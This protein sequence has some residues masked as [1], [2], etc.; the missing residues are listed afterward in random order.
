MRRDALPDADPALADR[1]ERAASADAV[2]TARIATYEHERVTIDTDAPGRRLFVL[3]DT[4]FPGW[5]A[6]VDG[7]PT[8][9]LRANVAFRAVPLSPGRH[10]VVFEYAP[11]SF[12]IGASD[13]RRGAAA[14]S[15][16]GTAL[17]ERR[18]RAVPA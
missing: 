8:P 15:R 3:S 9:I 5:R 13:R 14:R 2:G 6:T 18:R 10:R 7:T 11:A 17:A 16:V 4:W 12:R 1:P